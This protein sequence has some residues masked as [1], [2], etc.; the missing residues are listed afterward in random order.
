[1]TNQTQNLTRKNALVITQQVC[2]DALVNSDVAA[3]LLSDPA[4]VFQQYGLDIPSDHA[5]GF[6]AFFEAQ[7]G[8]FTHLLKNKSN[9]AS[10]EALK[11]FWCDLC[12]VGAWT[13]ALAIV[14]LGAVGLAAL[15]IESAIVATVAA[16]MGISL[17][18]ALA[19]L[20]GLEAIVSSGVTAVA[21]ALCNC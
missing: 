3:N 11:D 20:V 14:A 9:D 12:V 19:F 10:D 15:T 4:A 21:Q 8:N 1:M 18:A 16:F 7:M 2:I 17:E 13:L 5:D 6:N